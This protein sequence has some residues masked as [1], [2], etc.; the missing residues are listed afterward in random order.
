MRILKTEKVLPHEVL[1][2]IDNN[3]LIL[4]NNDTNKE[5][6]PTEKRLIESML[7]L[8]KYIIRHIPSHIIPDDDLYQLALTLKQQ[9]PN[10][11]QHEIYILLFNMPTTS[12]H[13]YV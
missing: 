6:T 1:T 10:L 11:T 9:F 5:A 12:V 4:N 7:N 2:Y 13:T 3:P 8:K